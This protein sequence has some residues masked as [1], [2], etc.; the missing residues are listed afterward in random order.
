VA[1]AAG[2]FLHVV[3]GFENTVVLDGVVLGPGAA[4]YTRFLNFDKGVAGLFLLGLYVPARTSH[5]P[6]FRRAV[7]L[8]WRFGL[9]VLLE[10]SLI[11]A[12][13]FAR[14]DPKLPAWWWAW[15]WSMV[16]LTALPEEAIFRGVAQQWVAE[17]LG[18]ASHA[19]LLPPVIAGTLF[20][21]AHVAGGPA[22]V[23]L[24]TV[25]GIGYGWIYASSGSMAAAIAAHAGLNTLHFLLFTYPALT[26]TS[27]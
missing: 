4:P 14:W 18:E 23:V 1:I 7:D 8:P 9:L 11:V 26:A 22:Y 15:V 19:M 5:D 27:R 25:A 16:F 24:A 10:L 6:L 20:G 21:V 2:L 3:P 17:R 12:L 13:G